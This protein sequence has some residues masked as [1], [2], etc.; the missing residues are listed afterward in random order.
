MC[1]CVRACVHVYIYI[2]LCVCIYMHVYVCACI[3]IVYMY[4]CIYTFVYKPNKPYIIHMFIYTHG[5]TGTYIYILCGG[6]SEGRVG[7]RGRDDVIRW[8]ILVPTLHMYRVCTC[9]CMC[10]YIQSRPSP[11]DQI[12]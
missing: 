10:M 3:H 12:C 1:V 5:Y 8:P 9:I 7:N 6:V 2:C 11:F 4:T